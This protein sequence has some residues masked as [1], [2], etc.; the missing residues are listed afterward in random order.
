MRVRH[1]IDRAYERVK[2]MV[3]RTVYSHAYSSMGYLYSNNTSSDQMG[4]Q[5]NT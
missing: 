3:S 1:T 5:I 4:N 2:T